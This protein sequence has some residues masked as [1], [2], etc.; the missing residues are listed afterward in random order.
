[1]DLSF[2]RKGSQEKK[3]PAFSLDLDFKADMDNSMRMT[4]SLMSQSAGF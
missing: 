1:M 2:Q 4:C 3:K